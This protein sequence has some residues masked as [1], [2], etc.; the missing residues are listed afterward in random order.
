MRQGHPGTSSARD[1]TSTQAVPRTGQR[2]TALGQPDS[3]LKHLT[4][5]EGQQ[6]KA[7][8]LVGGAGSVGRQA[9]HVSIADCSSQGLLRLLSGLLPQLWLAARACRHTTRW[10]PE[11]P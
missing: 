1:L 2:R 10:Q 5:M 3:W 9:H 6:R 4:G 8:S 11:M 7:C